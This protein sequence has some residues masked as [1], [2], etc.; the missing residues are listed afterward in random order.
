MST[1][2]SPIRE[3]PYLGRKSSGLQSHFDGEH[4]PCRPPPVR[5]HTAYAY[6]YYCYMATPSNTP[7]PITPIAPF[8]PF[9]PTAIPPDTLTSPSNPPTLT[10]ATPPCLLLLLH[11][12]RQ[13]SQP[14]LPEAS[15]GAAPVKGFLQR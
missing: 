6:D 12:P 4:P 5:F 8:A 2:T 11:T 10:H 7:T 14:K 3:E 1:K 9:T 15:F 13:A